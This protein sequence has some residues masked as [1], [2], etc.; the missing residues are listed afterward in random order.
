M[1]SPYVGEIRMFA[2]NFAPNGWEFC[3]GQI[4][5]ISENETLF[6]L[7]GTTLRRRRAGDLRPPRP[8]GP[9]PASPGKRIRDWSVRGSRKRDADIRPDAEPLAFSDGADR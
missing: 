7:I 9:D 3:N 2:G 5:A 4:V 6:N 1:A 8:T